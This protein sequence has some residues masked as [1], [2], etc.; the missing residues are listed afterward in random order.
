[1]AID[2]ADTQNYL[3]KFEWSS[4]TTARTVYP[5]KGMSEDPNAGAYVG[6]GHTQAIIYAENPASGDFP[7][8]GYIVGKTKSVWQYSMCNAPDFGFSASSYQQAMTSPELNAYLGFVHK[9]EQ[10]SSSCNI[11]QVLPSTSTSFTT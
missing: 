9:I 7:V 4:S 2:T 8:L 10:D 3:V 5:F 11:E 6:L 1:M